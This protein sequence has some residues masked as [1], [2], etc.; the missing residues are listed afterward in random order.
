MAIKI[1]GP[2][3]WIWVWVKIKPTLETG[4]SP[5]FHLRGWH[6]GPILTY[7]FGFLFLSTLKGSGSPKRTPSPAK[8]KSRGGSVSGSADMSLRTSR[9][10]RWPLRELPGASHVAMLHPGESLEVETESVPAAGWVP[11]SGEWSKWIL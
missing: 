7:S 2:P 9:P 11:R 8:T 10:T 1:G 3:K 4:F 6:L 5:C